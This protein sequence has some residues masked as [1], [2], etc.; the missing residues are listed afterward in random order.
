MQQCGVL[1]GHECEFCVTVNLVMC[2][3]LNKRHFS[4]A[5][6]FVLIRDRCIV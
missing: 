4:V 1:G 2:N 5:V 3:L 6:K